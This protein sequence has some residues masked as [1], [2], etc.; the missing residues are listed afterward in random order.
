[1]L[2]VHNPKKIIRFAKRIIFF[3]LLS[4]LSLTGKSQT[5]FF[6]NYSVTEGLAQ[7]KV[8]TLLQDTS[9]YIWLGTM[10]GL[11]RFDGVKFTNYTVQDGLSAGAVRALF[12]DRSGYLWLGHA[13][14][15]ITR[16]DGHKFEKF[17][18]S[19]IFFHSDITSFVQ[20]S[21]SR[22]WIT[23]ASSGA[24]VLQNP[25]APVR[26]VRY[27]QYKGKRLSDRVFGSIYSRENKLYFITDVGIKEF[28][29]AINSFINY[30]PEGLT[31]Y[32]ALTCMYEDSRG[33]KWFGTYHGGL[34]KYDVAHDTFVI[35]D[36]RDG[37]SSNWISTITEDH[38]GTV[39]VGTWGGGITCFSPEGEMKV[40]NTENGLQDDKIW[41]IRQDNEGNM[42]IGT[43]EHGL[44]IYKGRSFVS[45]GF[46]ASAENKNIHAIMQDNAGRYWF[47]SNDGVSVVSFDGDVPEQTIHYNQQNKNIGNQVRFIRKDDNG[48]L[49]LGTDGDGIF[50]YNTADQ[51]F[52][53][54][55]S[56]NRL[57]SGD[58]IVTAMV[59]DNKNHLWAGTNDGLVYYEPKSEKGQRLTQI[60]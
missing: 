46:D 55:F 2:T 9:R 57:L 38:H 31:H 29:P 51:K 53:Y 15:G 21:V 19:T 58:N 14:G 24:V 17:T 50:M 26:A 59:I 3:W 11:S 4:M 20:D 16:Y 22:L 33:N 30:N 6:D 23:S 52:V 25:D 45:Y 34:Y 18:L 37:L 7:S 44:S 56:L 32:F 12:Q 13:G 8:Y 42:L 28:D 47:G 41:S 27:E 35:Y 60:N 1:M 39:W 54:K 49:W 43:N 36:M 48:N 40:F 10:N 5:Y